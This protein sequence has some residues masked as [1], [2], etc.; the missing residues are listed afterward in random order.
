[1]S[2][3]QKTLIIEPG[4]YTPHSEG[5]E[6]KGFVCPKCNGRKYTS[7]QIGKD[8][9]KDNPCEYCKGSGW[10]K[11]KIIIDWIPDTTLRMKDITTA[12][13]QVEDIYKRDTVKSLWNEAKVSESDFERHNLLCDIIDKVHSECVYQLPSDET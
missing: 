12:D 13:I 10:M 2:N 4:V 3:I 11:A 1:M 7:E 5:M 8:K 9:Y 6:V